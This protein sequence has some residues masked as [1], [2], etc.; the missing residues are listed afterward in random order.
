MSTQHVSQTSRSQSPASSFRSRR[1]DAP[2]PSSTNRQS[3]SPGRDIVSVPS[4]Q[5]IPRIHQ[6]TVVR[7]K[8]GRGLTFLPPP[9]ELSTSQSSFSL[10]QPSLSGLSPRSETPPRNT[11][12]AS[13]LNSPLPSPGTRAGHQRPGRDLS[14]SASATPSS[15]REATGAQQPTYDSVSASRAGNSGPDRAFQ[16]AGSED[17]EHITVSGSG[18]PLLLDEL[19]GSATRDLRARDCLETVFRDALGTGV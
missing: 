2:T 14:G 18:C 11:A 6:P 5:S 17:E 7:T 10:R 9:A 15:G 1:S 13:K 8:S 19:T 4:P 12:A 3:A 16:R